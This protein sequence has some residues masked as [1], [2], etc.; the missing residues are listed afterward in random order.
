FSLAMAKDDDGAYTTNMAKSARR[1][2]IFIDYLRNDRGATAI[3][4]YS[5]RARPEAPVAT[6]LAW[7]ELSP[8]IRSDH[9][10]AATLPRRLAHL[11]D[12][13]WG[14]MEKLRQ[15]LTPKA[16]RTLKLA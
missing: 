3:A 11:R 15:T 1:G 6:P 16:K 2:K 5:T 14:E 12:D 13:P 10:T 9:F 7:E 8:A 4:A